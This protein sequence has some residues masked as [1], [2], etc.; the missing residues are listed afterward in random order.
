M[1][2]K[3]FCKCLTEKLKT[4]TTGRPQ[5]IFFFFLLLTSKHYCGI[6]LFLS[7]IRLK[8][9][10]RSVPDITNFSDLRH[11]QTYFQGGQ[12]N[13]KNVALTWQGCQNYYPQDINRQGCRKQ[14]YWLRLMSFTKDNRQH[15]K[16]GYFMLSYNRKRYIV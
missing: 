13:K 16:F 12:I 9:N 7:L 4:F 3:T 14:N 2:F 11:R 8:W 15:C 1:I 6:D 10:K 5:W